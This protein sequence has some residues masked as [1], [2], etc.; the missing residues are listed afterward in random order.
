MTFWFIFSLLATLR[1]LG[2]NTMETKKLHGNEDVNMYSTMRSEL[3]KI[4]K[5]TKFSFAVN[6]MSNFKIQIVENL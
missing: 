4:A 5:A 3:L 1:K 2:K 6:G